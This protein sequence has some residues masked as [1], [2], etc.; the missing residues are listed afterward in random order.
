MPF[1]YKE[2][3]EY[4]ILTFLHGTDP[5]L[6]IQ[7]RESPAGHDTKPLS[8]FATND[9][10]ALRMLSGEK[11]PN[12]GHMGTIQSN[13]FSDG[14]INVMSGGDG[15]NVFIKTL[16]EDIKQD[17]SLD[18]FIVLLQFNDELWWENRA[19]YTINVNGEEKTVKQLDI[20]SSYKVGLG[21]QITGQD[22]SGTYTAS[23]LGPNVWFQLLDQL[24]DSLCS[25]YSI[26]QDRQYVMG[27]SLGGLATFDLIS[28]YPDRFAAAVP[29]CAAGADP[30]P[31]NI[32]RITQTKVLCMHGAGDNWVSYQMGERFINELNKQ[33]PGHGLMIRVP[34]HGHSIAYMQNNNSQY[35]YDYVKNFL[36][37]SEKD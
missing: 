30:S 18:C 27:H 21:E 5:S 25:E 11:A 26:N 10:F 34:N 15:D 2:Y 20:H 3:K 37:G 16:I 12:A 29:N 23:A 32:A 9:S 4:P 17:E 36:F 33:Y 28:H 7:S 31:E 1:N 13:L 22:Y 14:S 35:G 8:D 6:Y 19:Q 24:Y